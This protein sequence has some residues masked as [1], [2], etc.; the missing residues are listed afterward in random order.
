M[1]TTRRAAAATAERP[2][3]TVDWFD[4]PD[5]L[6]VPGERRA[7]WLCVVL[8]PASLALASLVF[9]SVS[10]NEV[11]L[12]VVAGLVFVSLARGRLLGSSVRIEDRQIGEIGEVAASVAAR[13]GVA[14]PHVFVRDDPFV[15]IASTGIGEP[16]AL[17]ISSQY[18]HLLERGELAFLIAREL[19]H[20]AA[21]HT[22]ITSLLSISGRENPVVAFVFGPWLRKTEFTADRAAL[23]CCDGMRDALGAIAIATF[24]SIGR[25]VDMAVLAEQRRE[26]DAEPALRMGEWVSAVPY[27]TNRLDALERFAASPLYARMRV[28]TERSAGYVPASVDA[29]APGSIDRA[30]C[31]PV[32]RRLGAFC[33]DLATVSSLL[34]TPLVANVSHQALSSK[35]LK[36]VPAAILPLMTHLP[37]LAFGAGLGF[38][39]VTF[40]AYSAILV[41]LGGQTVG[42]LVME[43]RVRT[44]SN[45]RPSIAQT[46]WRYTIAFV[47]VVSS[48]ALVGLFMRVHPHDR[49]SRTRLVRGRRAGTVAVRAPR[50]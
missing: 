28:L 49:L 39:F 34:K 2:S 6:R 8:A 9:P 10:L 1:A 19:A 29:S 50:V 37:A 7:L 30:D 44:T 21:G 48:F 46:L 41:A 36:G 20:I 5:S 25:R 22:R 43:L 3:E 42:M 24:H 13:L 11:V 47:S 18:Y 12:L 38:M 16:Y 23:L 35:E 45:R 4:G 26:L 15:P 27:A 33:I 17:V 31:A 40:F 32:V 14:T